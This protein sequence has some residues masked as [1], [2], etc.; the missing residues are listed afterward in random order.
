MK[1]R[2][3]GGVLALSLLMG[4]CGAAFSDIQTPELAQTAAVLKSLKIMEGDSGGG[5]A[6]NRSL[7]RAEFAKLIVTAF[8][9]TDVTAYKNY[10]VFPDVPNTHWAAG[11]IN[12]AVKHADIKEKHII[13]GYAD[14]TFKPDRTINYGEACT[15]LMLM[16]GYS[17]EDI[18]LVWPG[19]YIARA[20]SAGLADGA[21][22]MTASSVMTRADAAIM[23]LNTLD[24]PGKEDGKLIASLTS[25]SDSEGSILLATSETDS[26]LR[27]N[28]ARFYTG[29]EE[30]VVKTTDGV[31]DDALIGVSGTI[32]YSKTSP[33]TVLTIVPSGDGRSERHTVRRVQRDRIETDAGETIKPARDVLLYVNGAV[34]KFSETWF[35]LQNGDQITLHYDASGS[36][37][38]ISASARSA[39]QNSFVYGTK[40]ALAVPSGFTIT[41]NGVRVAADSLKQYDVVTLDT[42]SKTAIV[43]DKRITGRYEDGT[44]SFKRPEKIKVL[45]QEYIVSERASGYFADFE[46]GD[47]ITLLLDSRGAVAAAYPVSTVRA[48][49]VGVFA[50]LDGEEAKILLWNGETVRGKLDSQDDKKLFGKV[51]TVSQSSDGDLSLIERSSAG[52]PSGD[53]DIDAGTLGGKKVA[54]DVRVWE[55]VDAKAPLYEISVSALHM[56]TVPSSSIR[57]AVT[58]SAGNIVAIVLNDVTGDAWNYGYGYY[59]SEK[60]ESAGLGED[61]TIENYENT[62][63]LRYYDYA[64]KS[65][66]EL[67]YKVISRPEGVNGGPI[68]LPKGAE[69]NGD[70]QFL[71]SI[72]LNRVDTV[73]LDAF[74]SADGVR[75]A[76]GYYPLSEEVQ[77]YLSGQRKF[78]TL[79]QAKADY[80]KFTLYAERTPDKGGKIRVITVS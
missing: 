24:T 76:S 39:S 3:L 23:L 11:Y 50:E 74:D 6:P 15:M 46:A 54:P 37:E 8:G 70:K 22:V 49:M 58:D 69:K 1:K 80:E 79:N 52:K 68:G 67:E 29:G 16:L 66:K 73:G 60:H 4:T 7:T 45:G 9:V 48:E 55:Q 33:N 31:L 38:L 57:T 17:I 32:Y 25:S 47:R 51:V 10:T 20:Q 19:D 13:H 21:S 14:G 78:V 72:R 77:V 53:W 64:D 36:L 44:P 62:V 2:V 5:F 30:P 61:D 40:D 65:E 28:Q 42:A 56:G 75:T 59:K 26:D 71:A 43:S 35:D 41:K 12:A 34:A 27:R 18:G 63:T